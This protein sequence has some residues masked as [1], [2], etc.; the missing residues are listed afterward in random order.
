MNLLL[1]TRGRSYKKPEHIP[2]LTT[3]ICFFLKKRVMVLRNRGR[4]SAQH[5]D[6]NQN[7]YPKDNLSE[8][9]HRKA[10]EFY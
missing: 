2:V 6:E 7:D 1:T 8:M 4:S 10:Y 9:L 3:E 5:L